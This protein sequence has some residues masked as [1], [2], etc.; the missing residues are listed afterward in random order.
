MSGKRGWGCRKYSGGEEE[1]WKTQTKLQHNDYHEC[2]IRDSLQAHAKSAE[3][4]HTFTTT[5]TVGNQAVRLQH[6]SQMNAKQLAT[7]LCEGVVHADS[8]AARTS[9]ALAKALTAFAPR[10][11]L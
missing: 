10:C 8:T 2:N 3:Q 6:H 7:A 4:Q 9:A 5:A 1:C 11:L